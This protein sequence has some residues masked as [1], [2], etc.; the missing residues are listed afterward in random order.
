[1][2]YSDLGDV[3]ASIGEYEQAIAI[4]DTYPQTQHNLALA[5][6]KQGRTQQA[7]THLQ[8]ALELDGDFYYSARVLA[9]IYQ[10]QGNE[11]LAAQYAERFE[12]SYAKFKR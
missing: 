3:D 11:Q 10:A 9:Q 2:A 5:L 7:I 4:S 8:R 6:L 12:K 1:M